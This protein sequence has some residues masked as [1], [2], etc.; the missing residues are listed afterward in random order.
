MA[1]WNENFSKKDYSA[2]EDT[3]QPS[4]FDN[5]FGKHFKSLVVGILILVI[6]I[7]FVIIYC[8]K[9]NI[10]SNVITLFTSALLGLIGFFAGTTKM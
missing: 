2:S 6:L 1:E 8:V 7:S 3:P 10:D 4:K 5:L 9:D